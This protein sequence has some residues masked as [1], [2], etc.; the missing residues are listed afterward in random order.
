MNTIWIW[1]GIA[2]HDPSGCKMKTRQ[3]KKEIVPRDFNIAVQYC[4][5]DMEMCVIK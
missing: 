1:F 2:L 5:S 4:S 3:S